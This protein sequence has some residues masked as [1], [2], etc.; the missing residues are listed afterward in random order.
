MYLIFCD[1]SLMVFYHFQLCF[2]DEC[3]DFGLEHGEVLSIGGNQ[4]LKHVNLMLGHVSII[5][6]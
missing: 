3:T 4:A 2:Y 1:V 6:S 5:N